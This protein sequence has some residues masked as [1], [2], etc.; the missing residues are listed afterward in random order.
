M[1]PAFAILVILGAVALWFFVI[2]CILPI[3][4]IHLPNMG[5]CDWENK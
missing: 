2:I 1:N 5:K 3:R 4:D